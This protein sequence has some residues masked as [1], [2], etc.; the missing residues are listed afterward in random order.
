MVTLFGKLKASC[1]L[2]TPALLLVLGA[3][4]LAGQTDRD[5]A[6]AGTWRLNVEKSTFNPLPGPKSETVTAIPGGKT[7]LEGTDGDG[8]PFRLSYAW[9]NGK[10]VPIDGSENATITEV[11][12]GNKIEQVVKVGGEVISKHRGALSKNGKTVTFTIDG[13]DPQGRP[14]HSIAVFEKQ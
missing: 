13:L 5:N 11:I 14:E 3:A 4:I 6:F 1:A 7:T 8:K 12:T 10:E 2:S 9:S